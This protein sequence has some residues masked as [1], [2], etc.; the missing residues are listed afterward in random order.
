M[1]KSHRLFAFRIRPLSEEEYERC[2]KKNTKYVRNKR[3]GTTVPEETFV[4]KYRAS[5]IYQAT[6]ME[7][8]ESLWDNHDVW[9]SM[10]SMGL[11]VM[12]GLDDI[13]YS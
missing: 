3:L 9:D 5:I 7:D 12:K 2:K 13:E 4:V 8:R 6:V 1:C 11:P 10:K